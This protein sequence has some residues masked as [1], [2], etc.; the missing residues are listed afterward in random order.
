M[1]G[2]FE[3]DKKIIGGEIMNIINMK[4]SELKE[5]ENNPRLINDEAVDRVA[6]SIKEFGFKVPIIVDEE[7]VIV[8]GHTRKLAAKSIGMEEVPVIIADDLT[9]GQI[10]AFRLADNKVAEFSEWDMELLSDELLELKEFENI[11]MDSFGFEESD[12]GLEFEEDAFDVEDNAE[13]V[14]NNDKG[15]TGLWQL[16]EHRL[17]CGDSTKKDDLLHLVGSEEVDMIFTDPPYNVDYE[18]GT[19]LKLQNDDMEDAEFYL[20]LKDAYDA[21]YNVTKPG[22]AIYVCHAD[23]EGLN[24]RKAFIESGF[25]LKQ[26]LIWVKNSLVMG[27]QDYHW[28]HEPIL[29]GW[30]PGAAHN[31]YSDRKKTTVLEES[32]N[33]TIKEETDGNYITFYNG[34]DEFTIKVPEYEV[35]DYNGDLE[36]TIWRIDKPRVNAD[37]PTMK[38]I[39]LCARAIK[40]SSK[41]GDVILDSFGGSGSTLIACEQLGR[42]ARIMEFDPVY[43]AVII[44][45][46][47]EYTGEKAVKIN[48]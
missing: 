35:I 15:L 4:I 1:G 39:E 30:K 47:E 24:F 20:F 14:K 23:S 9:E 48:G 37:H 31:W 45:R 38:P 22:G 5:Y 40:N 44:K 25:L 27:R 13:E 12:T 33:I 7:N 42:K 21:M 17:F 43:V 11:V 18:G 36:S 6:A 2:R 41:K 19:G 3:V 10:K 29:Y 46:W 34:M 28:K 16:G 32:T 26:C 8:A